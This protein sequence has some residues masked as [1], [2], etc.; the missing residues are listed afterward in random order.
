MIRKLVFALIL[1]GIAISLAACSENARAGSVQAK[2][3]DVIKTIPAQM[4]NVEDILEIPAKVQAD[5]DKV[6]HIYPPAGGRLLRVN[7]RPG[8]HVRKGQTVAVE[9]SSDIGQARSDY[10]KAKAEYDKNAR[11]LNRAQ[12]LFEHKAYSQREF[13]ETQANY[14]ESKSE[15]QRAADRLRV[16]GAPIEGS[17]SLVTL[18]APRDGSVL[19]IGAATGELSKS[20]DNANAIATI[21]DLDRI[22]IVGD[23]FEKD[24]ADVKRGETVDITLSAYPGRT[25]H[26]TIASIADALDPQSRTVKARVVLDNP[27]GEL[28]P[29][30]FATIR[31]RRPASPA[32]VVPATAVLHDGGDTAVMIE[33]KPGVY[34]RRLVTVRSSNAK[35]VVIADGVKPGEI[36]VSEGATLLRGGDQQ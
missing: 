32:I 28:K 35:E 30:M 22:W 29:E 9:E 31:V 7:V 36:V 2:Q 12:L 8:D 27:S 14:D 33:T 11:A 15:L 20:T 26:G 13:E 34:E 3:P 17:S 16:L 25:W 10:A 19:D 23:V 4:Q 21:A 24:L 18:V 5:P 1:I 6:V